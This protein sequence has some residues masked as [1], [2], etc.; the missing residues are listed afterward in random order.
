MSNREYKIAEIKARHSRDEILEKILH[1]I[2]K[3]W[4]D[5]THDDLV[6]EIVELNE[7]G[8]ESYNKFSNDELAE[9]LIDQ[10]E[11]WGDME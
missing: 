5:A 7:Y 2:R 4:E 10:R 1:Y 8:C 3:S 6:E 9:C 11:L